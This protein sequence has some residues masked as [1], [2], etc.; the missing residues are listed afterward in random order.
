MMQ[1]TVRLKCCLSHEACSGLEL[2]RASAAVRRATT[3]L[4][5]ASLPIGA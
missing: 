2:Q 5:L 3:V 1:M 4:L